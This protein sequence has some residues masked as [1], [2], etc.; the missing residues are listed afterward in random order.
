V[1]DAGVRQRQRNLYDRL[2]QRGI[3]LSTGGVGNVSTAVSEREID[4]FLEALADSCRE[5]QRDGDGDGTGP[6]T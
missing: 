1:A 6:G 2:L 5:M 3:L 4:A